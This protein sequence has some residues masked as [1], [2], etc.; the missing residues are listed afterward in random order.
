MP[1]AGGIDM[2]PK[3]LPVEPPVSL[4]HLPRDVL[5]ATLHKARHSS[6]NRS[7]DFLH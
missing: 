5:E 7:P 2:T 4:A 6:S 3:P 1:G